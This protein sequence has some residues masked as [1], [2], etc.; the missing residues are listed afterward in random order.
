[1]PTWTQQRLAFLS[2]T[3]N[4][5]NLSQSNPLRHRTST[6]LYRNSLS[7]LPPS[8]LRQPRSPIF[9]T[10]SH[11]LIP[12]VSRNCSAP[13]LAT[14]C[15]STSS[16][17]PTPVSTPTSLACL[18]KCLALPRPL[19]LVPTSHNLHTWAINSQV[20]P[21]SLPIRDS[22]LLRQFRRLPRVVLLQ[23]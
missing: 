18:R 22:K 9:P 4:R 3:P 7:R 20:L 12:P 6:R 23:T 1:M 13:C 8:L 5:L 11:H 15:L 19:V 2:T 16:P 14:V 21:R 10:S 17:R